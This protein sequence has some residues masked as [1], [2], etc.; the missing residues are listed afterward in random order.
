MNAIA[1]RARAAALS[2]E[3]KKHAYRQTQDGVVVSF[4]LHPQEVPDGLAISPLGTRYSLVV[5][6][7]GDDEQPRGGDPGADRI[8]K[9]PG[10][11]ASPDRAR[12]SWDEMSP[13]Q[14]AGVLCADAS[15]QKFLKETYTHAWSNAFSEEPEYK[16]SWLVRGFCSVTSRRELSTDPG[17]RALWTDLVGHYRT[18]Q[19]EPEVVG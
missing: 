3:A 2:C 13:A 6:E 11:A 14:Q 4:V 17:A 12:K 16:A 5:V 10:P 1:Q 8:E 18:W 7:I 15:F 9:T 19:R